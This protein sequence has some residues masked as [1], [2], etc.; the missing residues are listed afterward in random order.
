MNEDNA[1]QK[2]I[3]TAHYEEAYTTIINARTREYRVPY[4]SPDTECSYNTKED[5]VHED[6]FETETTV[7]LH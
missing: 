3:H 5:K 6:Y 7:F 4:I 2:D 1:L